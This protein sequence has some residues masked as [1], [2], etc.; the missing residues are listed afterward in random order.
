MN[1]HIEAIFLDMGN[2]LRILTKNEEHQARARLIGP[3]H[4]AL[5]TNQVSFPSAGSVFDFKLYNRVGF[6]DSGFVL[7]SFKEAFPA[8]E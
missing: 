5:L 1:D 3:L 7:H 6:H 8:G 4:Q 2:T